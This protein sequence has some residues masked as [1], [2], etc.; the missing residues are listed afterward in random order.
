MGNLGDKKG[1]QNNV[2]RRENRGRRVISL[3][4]EVLGV[5]ITKGNGKWEGVHR[6]LVTPGGSKQLWLPPV[7]LPGL[8]NLPWFFPTPRK[9]TFLV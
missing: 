2:K 7:S 8:I 4:G 6:A 5:R 3:S 1:S 9:E